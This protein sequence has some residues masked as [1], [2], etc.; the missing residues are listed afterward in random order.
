VLQRVQA[1]AVGAVLLELMDGHLQIVVDGLVLLIQILK[2]LE[3]PILELIKVVEVANAR[4]VMEI[5]V[6]ICA[7][8]GQEDAIIIKRA[9]LTVALI[10]GIVFGP[11]N[12]DFDALGMSRNDQIVKR[13]P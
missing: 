12:D 7:I 10:V 13:R 4:V 11:A 9:M 6:W 8:R 1:E 3:R 5:T 2:A